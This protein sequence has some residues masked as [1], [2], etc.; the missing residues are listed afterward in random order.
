MDACCKTQVENNNKIGMGNVNMN[1]KIEKMEKKEKREIGKHDSFK[2]LGN[3]VVS[4]MNADTLF[5]YSFFRSEL[6]I[7]D[8][9]L[10]GMK[11]GNDMCV[12]QYVRVICC[13]TETLHLQIL[14]D[15]LQ[16]ELREVL[17]SHCDL[18]IATVPYKAGENAQPREWKV[19][20]RWDGIRV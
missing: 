14:M 12:Y 5:T 17:T 7:S 6:S 19:V 2:F 13:M 15:V 16:K 4:L 3:M 1:G 18:V 10:S 20:I 9:T 8:K 11:K